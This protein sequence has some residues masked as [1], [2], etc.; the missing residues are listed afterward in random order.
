MKKPIVLCILDGYGWAPASKGNAITSANEPTLKAFFGDK[1]ALLS[2][3]G[4]DVGLPEGQ[5]G[6]SEVGHLNI[7]A[8]RV[9]NQPL[10]RINLS[11]KDG[12]LKNEALIKELAKSKV[13]HLIGLVSDGG[14]HSHINHLLA[15]LDIYKDHEVKVHIITDGR[16]VAPTSA[17]TFVD[18]VAKKLHKNQSIATISGR[19]YAMDRDK[20]WERVQ[21]AYDAIVNAKGNAV[22]DINAYIDASYKN[23]E[24]DEFIKPGILSGYEGI[25]KD[26]A[27]CFFNFRPDRA[28]QLVAAW[29][30][31]DYKSS[32]EIKLLPNKIVTFTP[33]GVDSKADAIFTP[34]KLVNGLGE[35]VSNA[36]MTQLRI[37]ETEKYPHVTYFFNGGQEAVYKNED[38]ILVPSPKVATY[39][40]QPEMSAEIVTEKL[41]PV[42]EKYDL[43][44]LNY[45]NCDMVGHTGNIEATIKAVEAVDNAVKE[46]LAKVDELG[47]TMIITADH[48]NADVM[49]DGEKV[50]TKHSTSPVPIAAS[51]GV[52]LNGGSLCDLAPTIVELLN[53]PQPKEM[54]GKSL[55]KK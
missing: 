13:I 55:I 41:L 38:R 48:G 27:I 45:A 3:S 15:L 28:I 32:P 6:N 18:Q 26:D 17:K 19:Y 51:N 30:N 42:L 25:Q 9:V 14:V 43:V 2:A 54:T 36:G 35:L 46:V 21:L 12:E 44:I 10:Q 53:L 49:L 4:P 34:L 29:T 50:V 5:M 37:A 39:D 24:Q 22:E 33:Y 7:G 31:K 47:G 11:I 16:D 8:G 23:G 52:K 40:M 20:R 1:P